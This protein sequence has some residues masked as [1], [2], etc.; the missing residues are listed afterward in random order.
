MGAKD[1]L[2]A[3]TRA[4]CATATAGWRRR[5]ENRMYNIRD[6]VIDCIDITEQDMEKINAM[7]KAEK[8]EAHLKFTTMDMGEVEGIR[9][10]FEHSGKY[11]SCGMEGRTALTVAALVR[12][13]LQE[14][15]L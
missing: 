15:G 5:K 13:V 8:L 9:L 14:F 11:W 7:F 4:G 1:A 3:P 6:K 2:A 12:M 10:S